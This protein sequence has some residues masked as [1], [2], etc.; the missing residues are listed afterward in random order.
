MGKEKDIRLLSIFLQYTGGDLTDEQ[1]NRQ[2]YSSH[3]THLFNLCWKN[4]NE[5]FKKDGLQSPGILFYM[6]PGIL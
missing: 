2:K 6:N 4:E 5:G 1:M 3:S